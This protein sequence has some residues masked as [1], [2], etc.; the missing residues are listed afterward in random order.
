MLFLNVS[1]LSSKVFASFA[2]L[3]GLNARINRVLLR[4]RSLQLWLAM[5]SQPPTCRFAAEMDSR[6]LCNA[7]ARK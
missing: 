3:R 2:K 6:A 7:D 5:A 4:A 1:W